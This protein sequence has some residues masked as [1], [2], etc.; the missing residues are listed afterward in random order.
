MT[1]EHVTMTRLSATPP[2]ARGRSDRVAIRVGVSPHI[3][4]PWLDRTPTRRLRRHPPP[5]RGMDSAT[6]RR[7]TGQPM[8]PQRRTPTALARRHAVAAD[9]RRARAGDRARHLRDGRPASRRGRIAGRFDVNRHTVRRALADLAS[10]GW[11]APS[12]AAAPLS[13]AAGSPI[14]SAR[15]RASPRSSERPAAIGGR[16]IGM[17]PG[18]APISP[19]ARSRVGEAVVRLEILRSADRV[20]ICRTTYG[21]RTRAPPMRP[22][23]FA[24]AVESPRRSPITAFATIV[25]NRPTSRR[26]PPTRWTRN[27][28]ISPGRALLVIDSIDVAL[29][30][31]PFPTKRPVRRRPRRAGGGELTCH[32]G[33]CLKYLKSGGAW[34]FLVGIK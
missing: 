18:A 26:R 17:E 28:F 9:R 16:L 1:D 24:R 13:R 5:C 10:A 12:A 7:R 33:G 32:F 29:A 15:A 20:P 19:A 21:C 11:C 23:C 3:Q 27:G 31:K 14:R 4:H 25:G 34:S 2:P 6:V 30:G 22:G 8:R